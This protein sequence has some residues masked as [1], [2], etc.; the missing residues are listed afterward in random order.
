M[1]VWSDAGMNQ[2]I[3][4][5]PP[6]K[7]VPVSWFESCR[8]YYGTFM[9][10]L[11]PGNYSVTLSVCVQNGE[12]Q[13]SL[14]SRALILEGFVGSLSP[15]YQSCTPPIEVDVQPGQVAQITILYGLN[16]QVTGYCPTP[17][18]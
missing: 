1:V 11:A 3:S 18:T 4:L 6:Q 2:R 8:S 17:S 13:A 9:V 10:G 5:S 14:C 15:Q 7:T 12:C 16:C